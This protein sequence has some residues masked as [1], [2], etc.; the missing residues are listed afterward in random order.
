MFRLI[1]CFQTYTFTSNSKFI[2]KTQYK[3]SEPFYTQAKTFAC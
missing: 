3:K 1:K 2:Q